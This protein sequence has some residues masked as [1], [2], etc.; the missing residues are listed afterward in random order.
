MT[1]SPPPDRRAIGV[2]GAY[3]EG[4]RR[5]LRAEVMCAAAL[6]ATTI[7]TVALGALAGS[8]NALLHHPGT[9]PNTWRLLRFTLAGRFIQRALPFGDPLTVAADT[10]DFAIDGLSMTLLAAAAV[11]RYVGLWTFLWGGILDRLARDRRVGTAAFFG[12]CG[13]Y[14][15]RFLRLAVPITLAYWAIFRWLQ[16]YL[17]IYVIAMIAMMLLAD[18]ARVRAVVEDR[19]SMLGALLASFRFVR[20][21]APDAVGLYVL[22]LAQLF[23]VGA[24]TSASSS[25]TFMRGWA[26][27]LVVIVLVAFVFYARLALAAGQVALFQ[28]RLAHAGYTAAPLPM[29][30]DSPAA[31]AIEN[32]AV[33]GQ[34]AGGRG[35]RAE[36][37][38]QR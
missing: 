1:P 7:T 14:F 25:W 29:W 2:I 8:P 19:R 28:S 13:V 11:V 38:G 37:K 20:R 27:I 23:V 4:W 31:E 18:F 32:L 12:T 30:P 35:Q 24:L 6:V 36:G 33:Q 17:V 26:G 9:S 21:N 5:V 10:I 15:F 16:D 3:V 34:R 22:G